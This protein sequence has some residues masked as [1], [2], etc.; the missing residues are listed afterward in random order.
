VDSKVKRLLAVLLGGRADGR[1][2]GVLDDVFLEE[3]T[4]GP[5]DAGQGI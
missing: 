4:A 5:A 2:G 3:L 1:P